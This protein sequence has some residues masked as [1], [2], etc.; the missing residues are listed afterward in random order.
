MLF[1][2]NSHEEAEARLAWRCRSAVGVWC[3]PPSRAWII[4]ALGS[5]HAGIGKAK[6]CTAPQLPRL[7]GPWVS[8]WFHDW[9]HGTL[10]LHSLPSSLPTCL[11][12]TPCLIERKQ[13]RS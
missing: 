2:N 10:L 8:I 6:P 1:S 12:H 11:V 5:Q 9:E 13:F 3:S 7:S 4:D